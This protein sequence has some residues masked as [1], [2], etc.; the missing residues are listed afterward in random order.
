MTPEGALA[1]D[2]VSV[3]ASARQRVVAPGAV[4]RVVA[5]AAVD[6]V[7]GIVADQVSALEPPIMFSNP[8]RVSLP[9]PVAVAPVKLAVTPLPAPAKDTVSIP[10]TSVEGVVAVIARD[11]VVEAGPGHVLDAGDRV[12]PATSGVLGRGQAPGSP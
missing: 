4:D 1:A 3:P 11:R 9:W 2:T 5:V 12:G 6:H 10:G 8:A 7:R